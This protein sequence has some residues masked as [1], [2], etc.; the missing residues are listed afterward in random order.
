VKTCFIIAALGL[1]GLVWA[2]ELDDTYQQLKQAQEKKDVDAVKKL[3][4]ET[5]K[6]AR[7][8]AA[9]E[10]P[11]TTDAAHWKERVEY[12]K[13]VDG[14]SEYA[15]SSTA[16]QRGLEPAKTIELVDQL[17]EQNPKSQY[18]SQCAGVYL[19]ALGKAGGIDKQLAGANKIVAGSPN[20]EDALFTL[21][22]GYVQK[23]PDRAL[24]FA[25]RLVTAVR[26]KSKPEGVS[27]EDWN[28]KK[29]TMLGHGYYVA[30][31]VSGNKQ[32]WPD[33]DRNMR[34]ALPFIG[35]EPGILGP[36]YFYL[37]LADYQ[38]GKLTSD[39][40]KIQDGLKYSEE[41]AKI[42]GPMQAQASRNAALIKQELGRP[43]GR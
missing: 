33:T 4:G 28:T 16:V 27:E 19:A 26:S 42:A 18:L 5:S 21:T 23:S 31:A 32:L 24:Q 41:S 12:A 38:L 11:A 17:I 39:R 30:G 10:Q 22:E 6:L 29:N 37:G 8:E 25:N 2:D 13:E 7:A 36:A 43:A 14:F 9:R 20:N 40:T 1:T 34:A 35:R 3:A 15:L